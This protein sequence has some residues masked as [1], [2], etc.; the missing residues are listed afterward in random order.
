MTPSPCL[1]VPFKRGGAVKQSVT[2]A[3]DVSAPSYVKHRKAI[4]WVAEIAELTK[5][6]RVVWCDGTPA[7]Y[8]GLC[9][10]MV[11]YG[12]LKRLNPKL[13]PNSY[14]AWSDPT[15]V[16]R[17][18]DRTFICSKASKDAGPTNNWVDPVAMR[19]TLDK[20]FE[21]SMRGRTMYVVPFSMGP[22]GSHIAHIGVELSDSP[23]VAVSMRIMTRMGVKVW[24]VLGKD[25][26]FAPCI[27]SVGAP[28][29]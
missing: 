1:A 8:D 5:P 9:Q 19:S 7:E 14:L 22:L 6:D 18:E 21:G 4:T 17:M 20:V 15:D 24:E 3:I 13:R 11:R 10:E 12:T 16:A 25:G 26:Y 28:L 2:S 27:S 23:Y 29:G